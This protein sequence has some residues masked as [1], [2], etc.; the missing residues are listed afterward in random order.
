MRVGKHRVEPDLLPEG[1]EGG[2]SLSFCLRDVD[3]GVLG[4]DVGVDGACHELS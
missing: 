3:E 4:G 1:P 2:R